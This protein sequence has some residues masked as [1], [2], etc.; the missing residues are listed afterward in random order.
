MYYIA[1]MKKLAKLL[2][3]LVLFYLIGSV[4]YLEMKITQ[5]QNM[6][7]LLALATIFLPYVAVYSKYRIFFRDST[8]K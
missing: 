7:G 4:G 6:N 8:N 2:V 5:S 1:T 3:F